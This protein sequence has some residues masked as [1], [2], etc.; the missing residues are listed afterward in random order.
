MS[1]PTLDDKAMNLPALRREGVDRRQGNNLKTLTCALY[2]RRRRGPRRAGECP[3]NQY[4][5]VHH[6]R[7]GVMA[8]LIMVLCLADSVMT[9]RIMAR[10]GVELNPL[11]DTLIAIDTALFIGVK[12]ALTALGVLLLIAHANFRI[13]RRLAVE[14]LLVAVLAG[15]V[16]LFH[17]EVF[18]LMA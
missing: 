5:D 6:W 7:T 11:M 9:L 3:Y 1:G 14:T 18:L 4:R 8:T 17:Y 15:Y 13:G 16:V 2:M 10:G 12:Y